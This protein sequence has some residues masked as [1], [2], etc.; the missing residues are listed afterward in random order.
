MSL[1]DAAQSAPAAIFFDM[2]G[3]LLDWQTGMQE[4]W[5][6]SCEDGCAGK[7]AFDARALYAK[8]VERRSW[9]WQDAERARA[10][11][12]DLDAASRAVV[13][14]AFDD[15][16]YGDLGLAHRIADDYRARRLALMAL[17]PGAIATVEA[18]RARGIA[19]AL[20]TNGGQRTQRHSIER[21]GLA[22]YFD[23]VIVEGEF[24]TGKPD[25]RVFRHALAATGAAPERAWMVGDSLEADIETPVRLGM[26]AIWID[27]AGDGL[28]ASAAIRPH[29]IIRSVTELVGRA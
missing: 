11:R 27:E 28:P 6:A 23:C 19:T 8:I 29:R 12:M 7:P 15:L 20:I 9:F 5:L 17:Y 2:D 13:A 22:R 10:G 4:S 21:F 3:T 26:H 14:A 1:L 25:E 16:G 24:G 18:V